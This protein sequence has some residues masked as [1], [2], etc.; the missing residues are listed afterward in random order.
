MMGEDLPLGQ[1]IYAL[2]LDGQGGCRALT[3]H[4][5]ASLAQPAWLH[6]DYREAPIRDWLATTPLLPDP[7]RQSLSGESLRPRLTR[8]GEGVLITLRSIHLDPAADTH[9]DPWVV[10]RMYVTGSLIL[11]SA[12][13]DS[14]MLAPVVEELQGGSGAVNGAG[15]L[16]AIADALVDQLSDAIDARHDCIIDME[17]RLLDQ[18][19]PPRGELAMLRKQLIVMRRYLAPQRDV[20]ARLACERLGWLGDDDRRRL[21]DIADR[22]GRGLE[23]LDSCI[24]R[25]ALLADEI[26]S[27]VADAL[28]RRT[29]TMSL[30]AMLFLPA[31]F[32]TGLF[33]V[34]LGGIPGSE[35]PLAFVL[36]CLLLLILA[37]CVVI[38]LK[39]SKWL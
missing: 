35:S 4:T 25:T 5:Q 28:N 14:A 36:F 20:L 18:Q 3:D 10:L 26:A 38:G 29:Y 39:R 33:G 32:L 17:D 23:D 2:Q 7:L 19:F 15:L 31:T 6:L 24:A 1:A 16:V 34:N 30:L 11:T 37:F 27:Q 21:Q 13:R 8:Q 22:L 9:P 12:H